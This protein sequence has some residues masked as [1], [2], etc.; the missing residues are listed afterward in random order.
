[1]P[2]RAA[3]LCRL[4]AAPPHEPTEGAF[5][6]MLREAAILWLG[7]VGVCRDDE[8]VFAAAENVNGRWASFPV[9]QPDA[10][11]KQLR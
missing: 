3:A 4:A 5:R 8:F 9:G 6:P 1:M 7:R 2:V 10:L 11:A